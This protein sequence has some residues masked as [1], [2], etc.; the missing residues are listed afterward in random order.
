MPLIKSANPIGGV[1]K[2]L[3]ATMY[4]AIIWLI[5]AVITWCVMI[6]VNDNTSV[7]QWHETS[8]LGKMFIASMVTFVPCA[9]LDLALESDKAHKIG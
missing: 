7:I 9:L 2:A 4:F 5:C 1:M 6:I 3:K 8:A